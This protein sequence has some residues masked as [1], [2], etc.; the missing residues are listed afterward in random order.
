MV[1]H[2][3]MS[4][5]DPE[6]PASMSRVVIEELLR[7]QLKFDG[8]VITDD[9]TMGAIAD[10]YSIGDAAVGALQAGADIVLIGHEPELQR[11]ALQA[12]R[13]A[14]QS[15]ELSADEID[16]HVYRVLRLKEKYGLSD[17]PVN[18]LTAEELNEAIRRIMEP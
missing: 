17:E 10:N 7:E 8:V 6:V 4:D 12:I 1:A 5:V 2:L 11:K 16:R 14:A 15:G 3:L 13:D 18:E 9:M